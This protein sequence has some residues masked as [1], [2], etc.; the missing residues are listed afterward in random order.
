MSR[1]AAPCPSLAASES[2]PSS[3]ATTTVTG[4]PYRAR[5][6][7]SRRKASFQARRTAKPV[8]RATSVSSSSISSVSGPPP[9][10][11][12]RIADSAV[13]S[14]WGGSFQ[15]LDGPDGSRESEGASS[16][17]TATI[18]NAVGAVEAGV[19]DASDGGDSATTGLIAESTVEGCA[20]K[21][22]SMQARIST[23][24]GARGTGA[25][26]SRPF[27]VPDGRQRERDER[28]AHDSGSDCH[29]EGL[30]TGAGSHRSDRASAG[31]SIRSARRA[32]CRCPRA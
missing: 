3:S 18:W 25:R 11:N 15:R 31:T 8:V 17:I 5:R 23:G 4:Q 6:C 21:D 2:S 29:L 1:S 20:G 26:P 30:R 27:P 7:S 16:P 28:H 14:S 19:S 13:G 10:A 12:V 24:A 22:A 32:E 9:L